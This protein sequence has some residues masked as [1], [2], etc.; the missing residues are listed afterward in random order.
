MTLCLVVCLLQNF[1]TDSWVN[2]AIRRPSTLIRHVFPLF[3]FIYTGVYIVHF[4][5]PPSL[6]FHIFSPTNKV[7]AGGE[8]KMLVYNAK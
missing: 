2:L 5:H 1:V 6:E 7:A 4:D 8:R 3:L